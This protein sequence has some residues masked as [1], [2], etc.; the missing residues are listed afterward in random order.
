[1]SYLALDDKYKLARCKIEAQIMELSDSFVFEVL[2]V[3]TDRK[4]AVQTPKRYGPGDT[5]VLLR[6]LSEAIAKRDFLPELAA[7]YR[8]ESSA[9]AMG[10][11]V[12]PPGRINDPIRVKVPRS[13]DPPDACY[14]LR[15]L[16]NHADGALSGIWPLVRG[17]TPKSGA[18]L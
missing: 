15:L 5:S 7:E 16:A 3:G 14:A 1:M 6:K 13:V 18:K 4:L 9:D 2:F 11:A 8:V 12:A 10:F 17:S